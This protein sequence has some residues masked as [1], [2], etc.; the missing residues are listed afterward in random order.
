MVLYILLCQRWINRWINEKNYGP[1]FPAFGLNTERYG[2]SL[3]IQSECSKI[4]TRIT[5]NRDTFCAV[6]GYDKDFIATVD[7]VTNAVNKFRNHPSIIRITNKKKNNQSF[8]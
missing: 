5:L 8:F 6:H 3:R 7:Q 1:N 4:Q 2:A